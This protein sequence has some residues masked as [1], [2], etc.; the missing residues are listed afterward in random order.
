[1]TNKI[2]A[3]APHLNGVSFDED[4]VV[5]RRRWRASVGWGLCASVDPFETAYKQSS[6]S[7]WR[8]VLRALRGWSSSP[9]FWRRA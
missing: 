7:S 3:G 8:R 4:P 1:M 2:M 9:I 5:E 6:W